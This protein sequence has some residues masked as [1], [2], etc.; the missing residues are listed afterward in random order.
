MEQRLII[1]QLWFATWLSLAAF[2]QITIAQVDTADDAKKRTAPI[3]QP[4]NVV[5]II[6]DDQT[7]TDFGFMG[8]PHVQTPNLDAFAAK[9]ARFVNGY[10]PSSVCRPSLVT[11]LTGLY[12]HQHG[13]HFNHPP[14]GFSKLTKSAEID[15]Q[16]FDHLRERGAALIRDLPTLPRWLAKRGYRCPQN[17]PE[18]S[19][20]TSNWPTAIGWLTEM[21]IMG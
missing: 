17:L 4:P 6:S 19:T 8:H 20:V 9:S 11:M 2:T 13:V 12:P 21:A 3:A 15:K 5:M 7:Y 14:P 10:V 16:R 1:R 18:E